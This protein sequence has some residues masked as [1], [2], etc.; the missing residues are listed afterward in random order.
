MPD[1]LALRALL[2]GQRIE[3]RGLGHE[4]TIALTPLTLQ[5]GKRGVAFLFRYGVAVLVGLSAT[6]EAELLDSLRP[7]ILEALPTPE[8]DQVEVLLKPE[9]EDQIEPSGAIALK[10]ASP[11]RLQIVANVLSKSVVLTHHESQIAATFDRIEPLAAGIRRK[12]RVDRKAYQLIQQIGDILL[13]QHRMVGRV[14]IE[15]KPDVLWDRPE[16]ERLYARLADEYELLERNRAI[17]RKLALVGETVRM[18]L[19]LVQD[20]RSVRLEWYIICLIVIEILLSV[21][22][23]FFKPH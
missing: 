14:A 23:I 13:T 7:R 17:D 1:S 3:T 5:V 9:S 4:D 6:E 20:Q 21:Y 15:D 8:I 2:L 19:E 18:L 10:D 16:L 22:E 11:E 12:G